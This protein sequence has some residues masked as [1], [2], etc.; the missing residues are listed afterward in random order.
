[1]TPTILFGDLNEDGEVHC[2][3]PQQFFLDWGQGFPVNPSPR[4]GFIPGTLSYAG[5]TSGVEVSLAGTGPQNTQGAG[6]DTVSG[7]ENL[8]G[9]DHADNL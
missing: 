8:T 1:M 5:A 3:V 7:F 9:S 4:T 6:T 2:S